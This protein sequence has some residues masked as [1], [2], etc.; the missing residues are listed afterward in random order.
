MYVASSMINEIAPFTL[1]LMGGKKYE[2]FVIDE[3]ETSLH[4]SKQQE[5]VRFFSRLNKK[6]LKLILSTH[7]DT[8]VSKLNN[9]YILSNYVAQG[10][11]SD[12]LSK[13]DLS[14]S[15]LINLDD[16]SVYEFIKAENG[17]YQAKEITGNPQAGYQF[18]LFTDSVMKL[19]EEA[20]QV[21]DAV[22][23]D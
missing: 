22:E 11:S 18:D 17:K 23:H 3:V 13:L 21:G 4:P 19:Y 8:F 20:C 14:E 7:S 9:L 10:K 16:L 12:I 6:G 5:L 2:R 1:A 15:D